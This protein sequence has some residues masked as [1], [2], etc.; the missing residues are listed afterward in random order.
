[1]EQLIAPVLF[2]IALLALSTAI[3]IPMIR[4]LVM[5]REARHELR[6]GSAGFLRSLAG[7]SVIGF[8]LLGTWFVATI[9]G[10]W[11]YTGDLDGAIAR[12]W[13]RLQ[14]VLEIAAALAQSD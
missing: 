2:G 1:M 12:S 4:K 14:I 8:W 6:Q 10:D 11:G 9:L 5:V 13:L 7:W 3:G